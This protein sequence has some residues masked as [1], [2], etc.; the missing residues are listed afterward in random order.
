MHRASRVFALLT[1][2]AI[3]AVTALPALAQ[4]RVGG[5]VKDDT[6]QPIKGASVQAA[7]PQATPPEFTSTTDDKGRWTM[8]GMQAGSW[9]FTVSADSYVPVVV[10]AQV[11]YLRVNAPI[12]FTLVKV[13]PGAAALTA[14]RALPAD[15]K[16]ADALFANERWDDAIAAYRTL[17]AKEPALSMINIQ[18]ARAYRAKQDYDNAIAAYQVVLKAEPTLARTYVELGG[19]YM[20]KGDK[21]G[22][23]AA[24]EKAVALDP[25][26]ADATQAKAM[27]EQLKK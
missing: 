10:R 21:A 19:V 11:A 25:N 15:L 7:H 12:D 9:V 27:L 4:G 20:Q 6:G 5:S 14:A 16:A 17:L 2:V 1:A 3:V 24:M 8:S 22:A 23:V 13:T 18:I 26:S